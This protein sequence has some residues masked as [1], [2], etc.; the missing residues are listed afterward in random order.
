MREKS[1]VKEV[2]FCIVNDPRTSTCPYLMPILSVMPSSEKGYCSKRDFPIT[3]VVANSSLTETIAGAVIIE[4]IYYIVLM[5]YIICLLVQI[6]VRKG[7]SL[8][9]N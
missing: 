3:R 6:D 4:S 5:E 9:A 2:G 8:V 1:A 7:S